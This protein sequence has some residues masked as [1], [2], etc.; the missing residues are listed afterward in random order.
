MI[1]GSNNLTGDRCELLD[2]LVLLDRVIFKS[3]LNLVLLMDN[4]DTERSILLPCVYV[5]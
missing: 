1:L 4:A 5:V 3:Y 2:K